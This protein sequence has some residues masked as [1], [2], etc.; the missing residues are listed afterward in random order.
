MALG[1]LSELLRLSQQNRLSLPPALEKG[2]QD[3]YFENYLWINRIGLFVGLAL[4]LVFGL[5]DLY[6]VPQTYPQVWLLRYGLGAPIIILAILASYR[7]YYRHWM[8]AATLA[9]TLTAGFGVIV[10]TS[11]AQPGE[12]GYYY[13]IYGLTVVLTFL[14]TIPGALFWDVV[15]V[16]FLLIVCALIPY[17]LRFDFLRNPVSVT[18]F[19]VTMA[20]LITLALVGNVGRYFFE[21]S[22]RRNFLQRLIIQQEE[23]RSN[24]LLLNVLPAPVAERLKRG[25]QVADFHQAISILFVDIVDFTPLSARL[26]PAALV[27]LLNTIFSAFDELTEAHTLEKIKTIGDAYMVVSG[28]PVPRG[29]HAHV[30]ADLALEMLAAVSELSQTLGE[31]LQIRIGIHSGP[32]VAGVIG[33]KK[34]A[35]DLWGDTVNTASRMES[36]GYPGKTQ[37]TQVVYE[38]L[39][40]DY[41]FEDRGE[42]EIKGKGKMHV[43]WLIGKYPHRA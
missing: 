28:I 2:F 39:K 26:A 20:F 32:A 30:L 3:W 23:D 14:F 29:D 19:M 40:D 18:V 24:A 9:V 43:Y 1:S 13:Y 42:L 35:Y 17:L 33:W 10:F 12:V 21:L 31:P 25:E 11:I 41:Q 27:G 5:V 15:W 4:W 22:I 7:P 34:F 36:H 37:V 8:R 16:S 6:A 38:L